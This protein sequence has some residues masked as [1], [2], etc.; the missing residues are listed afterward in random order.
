MSKQL[1]LV[2]DLKKKEEDKARDHLR[3]LE[4]RLEALQQ[5][6]SALEDY[7][8]AYQ[9]QLSAPGAI[10]MQ[11]R[12]TVMLYLNQV[13]NAIVGQVD[14]VNLAA[15]QVEQAKNVW[16]EHRLK[17][18]GIATLVENRQQEQHRLNEKNEQKESDALTQILFSKNA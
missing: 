10:T 2:L 18:K 8:L 1:A 7:A 13:Q 3:K 14:K 16:L 11:H 15:S 5:Q 6:L 4:Q 17:T 12:Q 9:Q